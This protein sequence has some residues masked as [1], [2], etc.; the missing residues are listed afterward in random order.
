MKIF[1]DARWTK[2]GRHD[3]ISRYGA[4]LLGALAKQ[5][6]VTMLICDMRQLEMLPKGIPYKM[7]PDPTSP[8][9]LLTPMKLNSWGATV[10]YSPMQIMGTLGRK[11][12]LIFT[13]H[14]LI[15][16]KYPFA[17]TTLNPAARAFWWLFHQKYW[18]GRLVLNMADVV[19]TVS[20]TSK[21]EILDAHLTDRPVEVIYNAPSSF[22]KVEPGDV[23]K[24]LVFMG[25]LMPYKNAEVLIR[26]LAE[27][28]EYHL[29]LTG[30]GTPDRLDALKTLAAQVSVTNRLTIWNGAS[31][32]EYAKILATAHAS[33]SASKAEGF[34]LPVIEAMAVGVPFLAT[35]MPIF[36]EVAGDAALYFNP[37]DPKDVAAKV[38][39]LEKPAVR[40]RLIKL[41]Y[42]Q[43]AKFSWDAS[44]KKL[45]EVLTDLDKRR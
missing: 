21:Q 26:A 11:Y 30:R 42:E 32:A 20:H 7:L 40:A 41:G 10:V 3:G 35:D 23:K 14:D 33:V 19:A 2:I 4:N 38:R 6:E 1:F 28:P 45:L 16:Y 31:D 37:D 27:L 24:E 25:T 44:A 43:A 8:M 12:K 5:T 18:P 17:P 29:H 13:L 34:G 22:P 9:E 36:H 15:Y 39:E